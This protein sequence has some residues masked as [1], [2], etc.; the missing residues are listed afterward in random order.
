MEWS[1]VCQNFVSEAWIKTDTNNHSGVLCLHL[2]NHKHWKLHIYN[3]EHAFSFIR[4]LS[5]MKIWKRAKLRWTDQTCTWK[6]MLLCH[7][8]RW[9]KFIP[10]ENELCFMKHAI[11]HLVSD[12]ADENLLRGEQGWACMQEEAN[13]FEWVI[14]CKNSNVHHVQ[15]MVWCNIDAKANC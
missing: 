14:E 5:C 4:F 11:T 12:I 1:L 10:K 2:F 15:R 6:L 7:L 3:A 9:E 13:T 8:Q